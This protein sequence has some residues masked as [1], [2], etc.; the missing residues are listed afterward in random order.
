VTGTGA[1][2]TACS[3]TGVTLDLTGAG[4]GTY[5]VSVT[6]T[7]AAG[8]V[9]TGTFDYTLDTALTT[10]TITRARS[11]D[12]ATSPS[13]AVSGVDP[14][15]TSVTCTVSGTGARVTSCTSTGVTLDLSAAADSAYTVTV[16]VR[17]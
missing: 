10:P 15:V 14:D 5:T 2:V 16:T 6:V 4:D 3:A 8:N 13:F 11:L 1:Q 17:D 12:N 7:D 9:R